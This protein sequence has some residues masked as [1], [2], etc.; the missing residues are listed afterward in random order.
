MPVKRRTAKVRDHRITAE[1]IAA[2]GAGDKAA[3]RAVLG[4]KPWEAS[5]L[6]E[7]NPHP[8]GSAY[9]LSWQQSRDLAQALRLSAPK[10]GGHIEA[11]NEDHPR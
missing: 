1:A 6:D 8:A 3:L 2:F 5:P 10:Q 9:G 7:N 11:L 4:L